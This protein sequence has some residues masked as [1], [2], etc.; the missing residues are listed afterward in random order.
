MRIRYAVTFEFETRP[1][2]MQNGVVEAGQMHTCA[3]R[4][5]KSA[6]QALRPVNWTSF[7][8]VALERLDAE[9]DDGQAADTETDTD[10]AEAVV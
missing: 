9:V 2:V 4:A 5:I 7:V 6:R 10:V 1:P 8:F 3:S